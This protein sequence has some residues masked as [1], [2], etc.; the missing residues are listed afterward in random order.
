MATMPPVECPLCRAELEASRDLEDH[1]VEDHRPRE[2]ANE[3]VSHWEE[4]ELGV[5]S[6]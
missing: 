2:L 1:L 4:E 3:I 5:E 6:E